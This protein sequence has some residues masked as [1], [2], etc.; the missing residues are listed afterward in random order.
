LPSFPT[1][2][3][4]DLNYP[5]LLLP[6]DY[7]FSQLIPTLIELAFVFVSPFFG[8]MMRCMAGAGCKVNVEWFIG[9]K[10][11]LCLHPINCLIGHVGGKMV[12]RIMR[13]LNPC[14]A[15]VHGGRPL[16]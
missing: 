5:H 16:I 14:D 8:N 9:S 1:R 4:S 15:I 7:L 3:S 12:F 11:L 13:W 6:R 10:C 2:R